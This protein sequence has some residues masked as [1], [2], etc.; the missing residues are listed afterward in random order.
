MRKAR[1]VDATH[2]PRMNQQKLGPQPHE[3]RVTSGLGNPRYHLSHRLLFG[4]LYSAARGSATI[5]AGHRRVG[6]RLPFRVSN[7]LSIG[8]KQHVVKVVV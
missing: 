2:W 6:F 1:S 5:E 3:Q 4:P 7:E 8:S